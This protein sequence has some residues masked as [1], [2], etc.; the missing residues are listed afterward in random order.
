MIAFY[1]LEPSKNPVISEKFPQ[2]AKR[3]ILVSRIIITLDA[4]IK[5][6]IL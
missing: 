1:I 4:Y 2:K 3:D 6:R 5:R